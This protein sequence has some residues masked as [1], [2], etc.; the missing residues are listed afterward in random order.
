[1]LASAGPAVPAG[2]QAMGYGVASSLRPGS[3]SVC[4]DQLDTFEVGDTVYLLLSDGMGSG[5]AAHREAAMT[6]RLLRQFLEA[7]IEPGGSEN[8]EHRPVPAGRERRR[9]H[10]H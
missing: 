9:L 4:G 2:A 6:V 3:Q 1:M 5:E 8:P 10:H 7:G